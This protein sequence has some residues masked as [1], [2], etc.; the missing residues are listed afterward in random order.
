MTHIHIQVRCSNDYALCE[1]R[2]RDEV[3]NLLHVS[4]W[5]AV[6]P[7]V[8]SVMTRAVKMRGRVELMD[9]NAFSRL[10]INTTL[11]FLTM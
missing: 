11:A 10:Q 6:L 4:A 1:G 7:L 5:S 8:R 9:G 2:R 3:H